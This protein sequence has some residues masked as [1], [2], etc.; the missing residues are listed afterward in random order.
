[1]GHCAYF[2][3]NTSPLLASSQLN[4]FGNKCIT[5]GWSFGIRNLPHRVGYVVGVGV[6]GPGKRVT[7]HNLALGLRGVP[8][9]L[10]PRK[11]FLLAIKS[12][13]RHVQL[14]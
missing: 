8:S 1:M 2:V 9:S 5:V 11:F 10:P 3:H 12:C 13:T 7:R 14:V 4:E 6:G